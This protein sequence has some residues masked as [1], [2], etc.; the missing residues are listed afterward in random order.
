MNNYKQHSGCSG[1]NT[2]VLLGVLLT[3]AGIL[4]LGFNLGWFDERIREV[5]FSWQ[6]IF[7]IFA[8]VT[9]WNRQYLQSLFWTALAVFFFLPQ[10]ARVFPEAL[11]WVDGDF[12]ANYW[13]VLIIL[14]G[15]G[16]ILQIFFGKGR[17]ILFLVSGRKNFGSY[18]KQDTGAGTNG[19]YNKSIV[20]GGAEDVF[21]ESEFR[22]GTIEVVFGGVELDLS[23]TTLPEGDT[24][25]IINAVFGGVEVRV[26]DEWEVLVE[27]GS[28]FGGV[29]ESRKKKP[30][31][32]ID[33]SRR[34]IIKGD[35][36]FG[37]VEIR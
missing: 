9:L 22:G 19:V 20:F 3:L 11:P 34:L 15:I 8:I 36:V 12:A 30:Q 28:T 17:R 16:V 14:V 24:V 1:R 25:L 23:K 6:I 33:R 10:I 2:S 26:P 35:V 31:T 13:P 27:I 5:L 21:L 32:E 18:S 7:V 29:E 37:G 4:F